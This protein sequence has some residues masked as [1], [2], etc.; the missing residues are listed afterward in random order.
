VICV[1][2]VLGQQFPGSTDKHVVPPLVNFSG[3]ITGPNGKP[4]SGPLTLTFSLYKEQQDNTPL[5]TEIQI[6]DADKNGH[7]SV[8]LGSNS[9]DGLPSDIF[10][11][12]DARWLAVEAEGQVEQPRVL[13]LSVP[14]ALKAGDADTLGGLPVS[15]FLTV[16]S[17]AT[18]TSAS[19]AVIPALVTGGSPAVT[20]ATTPTGGGTA[21]FVPLWTSS[22]NLG[23]SIL[24]QSGGAMSVNGA[25]K[26][27]A[28]GTAIA[29]AGKNSQPLEQTA[30]S[31]SSS[32]KKAIAQTFEWQAEPAGNDTA[33]PSAT[34]NLLFGSGVTP[35]ETGLKISSKG[36]LRF[37]AGQT[38]PGGTVTG[39]ETIHGNLSATNLTVSSGIQAQFGS[40]TGSNAG[41]ILIAQ[42]QNNSGGIGIVCNAAGSSGIGMEGNALGSSGTGV[43]GKGATGVTGTASLPSGIGVE[44]IGGNGTGGIGV[45]GSGDSLGVSGVA[46][47]KSITGQSLIGSRVGVWGDTNQTTSGAAGLAGTADDALGLRVENNSPSGFPTA[48]VVN[49][50]TGTANLPVFVAAGFVGGT[51]RFCEIDTNA[52]LSCEGSISAAVAVNNGRQQVAL[53]PVEAPQNWFEDFGSG[54]LANG[55][56][57][58]TLDP[59]FMQT[60]TT[61][62]EYHVFLTPEGDCRGLYVDRKTASGFEV[63][64]IG[65]GQSNVAFAYRIVAV[66]RGYESVRLEDMTARMRNIKPAQLEAKTGMTVTLPGAHR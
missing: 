19:P 24:F 50:E 27:P 32:L 57:T 44:G 43:Q 11:A 1:L 51:F 63:H 40:F 30:S 21:G 10:V 60:V 17:Q 9:R 61:T 2:P 29:T 48:S 41:D 31:F 39:G 26:F 6:V 33:S 18:Q 52:N 13:L 36:L 64:E 28:L 35:A 47:G 16:G 12:G 53:H 46:V 23:N 54:R 7:Y 20:P 66:R 37:A 34:L 65:G 3:V 49:N 58:V 56:A 8:M 38:F 45:V 15:S 25:F 42:N 62:S 5:W 14:Y 55:A 59:T 4:L 22:T